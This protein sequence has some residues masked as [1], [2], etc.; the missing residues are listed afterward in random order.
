MVGISLNSVGISQAKGVELVAQREQL[1]AT[2]PRAKPAARQSE[3][4]PARQKFASKELTPEQQQQVAELQQIDRTVRAHEQA[5]LSAGHGV[6]TSAANFSYTYGPDG[7]QYAVGGEV[8]IDTSAEKKP[9]ANID[10]GIRIQAAAL[11]PKDPSPQDYRVA[12]IGGQ[13]EAR[14]RSDLS[15]QQAEE[16]TLE[17]E[18]NAQQR[19]QARE[20]AGDSGR[21]RIEQAYS[22]PDSTGTLSVFA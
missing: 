6:V 16:R 20:Q 12:S 18:R 11:A 21:Q 4:Q 3:E 2:L 14:G 10:K 15:R 17:A 7:R 22:P 1:D 13:L 9:E 19:E 8:G 5:H